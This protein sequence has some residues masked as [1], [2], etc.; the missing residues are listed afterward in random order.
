MLIASMFFCSVF[1]L[2]AAMAT[3][4]AESQ[5]MPTMETSLSRPRTISVMPPAGAVRLLPLTAA[6][7]P[8]ETCRRS[9]TSAAT[10]ACQGNPFFAA[11]TI[12]LAAAVPAEIDPASSSLPAF[13]SARPWPTMPR[14]VLSWSERIGTVPESSRPDRSMATSPQPGTPITPPV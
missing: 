14:R 8:A 5:P 7:R 6:V 3:L 13:T 10:D 1:A 11:S 2:D 4:V 12:S 9:S